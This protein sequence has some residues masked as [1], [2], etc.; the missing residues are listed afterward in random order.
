[1]K[2]MCIHFLY[3]IKFS[4]SEDTNFI[5][6]LRKKWPYLLGFYFKKGLQGYIKNVFLKNVHV[7]ELH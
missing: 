7:S 2:K 5:N 3:Y 4:S 1:M 6:C